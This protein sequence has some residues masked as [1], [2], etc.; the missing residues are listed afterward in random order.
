[1]KNKLCGTLAGLLLATGLNA[2][3]LPFNGYDPEIQEEIWE[4]EQNYC[5]P[6]L[7]TKS[8]SNE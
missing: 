7:Y 3:E 2:V 1:M 6:N 8:S 5:I 4:S